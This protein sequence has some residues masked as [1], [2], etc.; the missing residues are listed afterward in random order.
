MLS[1]NQPGEVVNAARAICRA[2]KSAGT[3]IHALADGIGNG[4]LSEAE[5]K[6]LYDAGY[7]AGVQATED[8]LRGAGFHDVDDE[9]Y[10]GLERMAMDCAIRPERLRNEREREFVRQMVRWLA[11]GRKL[12]EKQE[13]WLRDCHDRVRR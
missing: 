9:G 4:K 13:T 12:S 10:E 11:R 6:R 3:D 8:K 2:L 7:A 5:M 1:S